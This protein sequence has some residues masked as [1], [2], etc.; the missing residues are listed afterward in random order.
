MGTRPDR[1]AMLKEQIEKVLENFSLRELS[2][3]ARRLSQNYKDSR[4]F[5]FHDHAAYLA[6]RMPATYAVLSQVLHR[7]R[8]KSFSTVLDIG[9]GPA[10]TLFALQELFPDLESLYLIERDPAFLELGKKLTRELPLSMRSEWIEADVEKK[11]PQL[12]SDLVIASYS[13]GEITERKQLSIA[14]QLWEL[15]QQVLIFIEPGTPVGFERLRGVR[16]LLLE[17][18]AHL[19]APCSHSRSCPMAGGDWCHFSVRLARSSIHR[20]AKEAIRNYEDE[21]FAYLLFSRREEPLVEGRI[22]R[23]P[24]RGKGHVAF[25]LCTKEGIE[26][27]VVTKKENELFRIAK[28]RGWGDSF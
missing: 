5:L 22:L 26:N 16:T 27:R 18:G 1:L 25:K 9:S 20:R 6:A 7:V 10:T 14:Q 11:I 21:K 4:P 17:R 13:L 2:Q 3:S 28:K 23:H 24:R 12:P 15:T 8:L 19:L